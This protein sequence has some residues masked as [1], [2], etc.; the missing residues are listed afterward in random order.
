MNDYISEKIDENAY[1]FDSKIL[2]SLK[3]KIEEEKAS[4]LNGMQR[5]VTKSIEQ[6]GGYFVEVESTRRKN[7]ERAFRLVKDTIDRN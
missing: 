3:S 4:L 7:Y 1:Y 6:R 2:D 5:K